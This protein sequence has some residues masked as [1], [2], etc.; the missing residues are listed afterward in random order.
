VQATKDFSL[1]RLR[2]HSGVQEIQ[3]IKIENLPLVPGHWMTI[4]LASG[5]EVRITFKTYFST[6]NARPFLVST[7]GSKKLRQN[8]ILDFFKEFC[9]LTLGGIKIFLETNGVHVGTGLPLATRGFYQVFFPPAIGQQTVEHHW[10]LKTLN[11]DVCCS[12]VYE[13]FYPFNISSSAISDPAECV[14]IF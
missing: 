11:G 13:I 5:R 1:S 6:L 4:I 2:S 10:Q 12:V 9:N 7:Y 3:V 8:Q 14:E